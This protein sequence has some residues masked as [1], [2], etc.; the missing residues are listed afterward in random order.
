MRY[1]FHIIEGSSEIT[2]PEGTDLPGEEAAQ[3]EALTIAAELLQEFPGRF[4]ENSVLEVFCEDGRR[5]MAL[6]IH[7]AIFDAGRA[8]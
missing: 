3:A 1:Y 8:A 5:I 2:D 7:A 6:P 4:R